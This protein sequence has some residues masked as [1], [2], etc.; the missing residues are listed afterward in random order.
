MW[1]SKNDASTKRSGRVN[2]SNDKELSTV[3]PRRFLESFSPTQGTINK[4]NTS[5]ADKGAGFD[6]PVGFSEEILN[7]HQGDASTSDTRWMSQLKQQS[8]QFLNEQRGSIS[9]QNE[10][11]LLYKRGVEVLI[12]KIFSIM[13][14]FMFEFN[15]VASG[16]DLQVSGTISGEV[17]EVIR[18]NKYKEAEETRRYFRARLSTRTYSLVIRGNVQLID[19]FLLPVNRAMALSREEDEFTPLATLN[20]KIS[21][22]GLMWRMSDGFPPVDSLESLSMWLFGKLIEKSKNVSLD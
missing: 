1:N 8:A 17:S 7:R 6:I 16:T 10:R 12:D 20:V 4:T 3:N 11:D 14:H 15:K 21:E 22:K 5:H 13:Q 19:F 18:Y 9:E 2:R